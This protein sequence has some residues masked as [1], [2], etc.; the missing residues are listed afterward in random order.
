[1]QRVLGRSGIAVSV[2]ITPGV[3]RHSPEIEL[4]L[5]R[6]VQESLGNVHRHSGSPTA[7]IRLRQA[8]GEIALDVADA[9]KGFPVTGAGRIEAGQIGVGIAGM[10]ERLRHLGGRLEISSGPEGTILRAVLPLPQTT[11]SGEN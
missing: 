11:E 9:G 1:M 6:I 10:R 5:L 4:A 8:A 3:T 7:L 2:E